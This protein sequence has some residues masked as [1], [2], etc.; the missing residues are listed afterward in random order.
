MQPRPL[1][2][3][4][5]ASSLFLAG[6]VSTGD[7]YAVVTIVGGEKLRVPL[8]QPVPNAKGDGFEVGAVRFEPVPHTQALTFRGELKLLKP[9][10]LKRVTIED[11]AGEQ[12][13]LILDDRNP[14]VENAAWKGTVTP[15]SINDTRIAWLRSLENSIPVYRFTI[16]TSDGRKVMLNQPS[17]FPSFL[18]AQIRQTLGLNY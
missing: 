1:P 9:A 15:L 16:E 11:I 14:A 7:V 4:L 10:T 18:K 6:C 12:P 17:M 13:M 5:L 3:L 8:S 2:A